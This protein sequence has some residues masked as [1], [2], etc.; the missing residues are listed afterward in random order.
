MSDLVDDMKLVEAANFTPHVKFAANST[1]TALHFL[2]D[3]SARLNLPL[4]QL[5]AEHIIPDARPLDA[6]MRQADVAFKEFPN[7][8]GG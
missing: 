2:R 8:R 1:L 7:R 3:L 6:Q 5:T 4:D